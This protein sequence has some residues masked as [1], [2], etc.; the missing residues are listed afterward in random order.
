M[1]N[2]LRKANETSS[3]GSLPSVTTA[4]MT[5]LATVAKN[6]VGSPSERSATLDDPIGKMTTL[7]IDPPQSVYEMRKPTEGKSTKNEY[8]IIQTTF[9][10][11]VCLLL[12]G[13]GN[14]FAKSENSNQE[15]DVR[16]NNSEESGALPPQQEEKI[17][18][19][20]SSQQLPEDNPDKTKDEVGHQDVNQGEQREK[21]GAVG[22]KKKDADDKAVEETSRTRKNTKSKNQQGWTKCWENEDK[23]KSS[24]Q[25]RRTKRCPNRN[26]KKTKVKPRM[27]VDN[28]TE[29]NA[30]KKQ[31]EDNPDKTK[32]E[33]GVNQGEQREKNGDVDNKEK[34]F[35]N[36]N[37][38]DVGVVDNKKE[39]DTVNPLKQ[40][41]ASD[42]SS[43]QQS[44]DNPDKTKDEVGVNQD[45]QR[46]KNGDVD[47][48]EKVFDN[49]NNKDGDV[50]DNKKEEVTV[51]PLKQ[52]TASGPSSHQLPEGNPDKTKHEVGNQDV[53]QGGIV[54]FLKNFLPAVLF[55]NSVTR[56]EEEGHDPACAPA[57]LSNWGGYRR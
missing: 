34:V 4:A 7:N 3:A 36:N 26:Q 42:P 27:E 16:E 2:P 48:K 22:N 51:N 32:D 56:E 40:T 5:T 37:N 12:I 28:T 47:N 33:V 8:L 19:D 52:T 30:N 21:K 35:D 38:K 18:S 23:T 45:E 29:T 6:T 20:P 11:L 17:A 1:T 44:E 41:T 39:E 15:V 43:H 49:N 55:R 54:K 46:E 53:K 10:I 25:P 14:L 24:T 31:P 50:V 13:G 57:S 9:L